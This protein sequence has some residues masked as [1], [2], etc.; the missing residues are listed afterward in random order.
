[1]I[2]VAVSSI[3]NSDEYERL[4]WWWNGSQ[5]WPGVYTQWSKI[6]HQ[7]D[8]SSLISI[9][10]F[11]TE[12]FWCNLV[13][14]FSA[15]CVKRYGVIHRT[16]KGGKSCIQKQFWKL[17]CRNSTNTHHWMRVKLLVCTHQ[18]HVEWLSTLCC[19]Q[20]KFS[21]EICIC[22]TPQQFR[23]HQMII[24]GENTSSKE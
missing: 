2:F 10:Y 12:I 1:M 6:L 23:P 20:L 13:Q 15:P 21:V 7:S 17:S 3:I 8:V 16:C 18:L 22:V 9:W 14:K 19:H 5:V 4:A 24:C 11:T